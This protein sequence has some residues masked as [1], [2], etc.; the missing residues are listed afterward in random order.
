MYKCRENVIYFPVKTNSSIFCATLL[1]KVV[2]AESLAHATWGV[3][4]K[5]GC[6][7]A[8]S[9]SASSLAGGSLT[10][11]SNAAPANLPLCSACSKSASLIKPPRPVLIKQAF[12]F[13]KASVLALISCSVCGVR[14]QCSEMT[15]A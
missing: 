11:T 6:V 15:S 4:N 1:T 5:F 14:G 2:K 3:I 13:I 10:S 12:G 8:A 7:F 9:Q